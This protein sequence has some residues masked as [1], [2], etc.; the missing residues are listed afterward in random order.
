MLN[1]PRSKKF[2]EKAKTL[3][4]GGVNSPVRAFKAVGDDPIVVT[5]A[6]GDRLYD[7]DGKKYIDYCM[8]WGPLILGHGNIKV[9]NAIRK[10]LRNGT[11]FGTLCPLEVRLAE[12]ITNAYP[13]LELIR[14]VNSGTEATMSA[15]RVARAFTKRDKIVKFEGGYHG[16]SD[17]F[18][19]KAGSGLTTLGT[20]SSPGV[21][22]TFAANTLTLPYNNIDAF[23]RLLNERAKEISA[24]IIEP[25]AGNM[26]IV[27]PLPGFLETVR[28]L[29]QKYE[30]V[31][32]FDEVITGFRV[33]FSGAQGLFNIKPD[34]TTLGKIIGGGLPVGA[35]GGREDIMKLISPEGPVYQAGTLSGNPVAMAAGIA[36]IK[37]IKSNP[38]FYEELD[39][40]TQHLVSGLKDA[41]KLA[42]K[43]IIINSIG[44]MYTPFFTEKPVTDL[45]SAMRSDTR[46]Y[47]KFFHL[48][49]ESGVYLPPSQ[50]EAHFV[51][52]SH[53]LHDID[54]TIK[55]AYSAFK[56][57]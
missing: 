20:P 17:Q 39:K 44:S 53:T 45:E 46:L 37:E 50:F 14:M 22:D 52:S 12:L 19:I 49:F 31:L 48:M 23:K 36:T 42:G 32:I 41:A 55:F 13:S 27:L 8:S 35:Y 34:M 30:I 24:V 7:V 11:S 56:S 54:R 51:S 40:K 1:R 57:L 2:Y 28:E 25:V 15:V 29:T 47:A 10:A 5:R 3:M 38:S 33:S 26:G 6:K 4:P 21:P 43:K 9:L 16:H 18:L